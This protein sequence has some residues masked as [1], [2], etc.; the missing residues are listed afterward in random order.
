MRER[1]EDDKPLQEV[2]ESLIKN[3]PNLTVLLQLG[4]R[5][6]A[7][8]NT[9]PTG[10][11]KKEFK[12]EVYPR[13]FKIK[14]VEYGEVFERDCPINF[15]MRFTF[16]TDARDDYFTRRIEK[17][18][19]K[20]TILEASGTERQTSP[21]GPNLRNGIAT[22]GI[23]LPEGAR[24]GD[25]ITYLARVQDSRK[26]FENRIV[27]TVKQEAAKSSGGGGRRNPP[28]DR[29][30]DDR[31]R[32]RRLG[33]PQIEQIYRED[34][35]KHDFD[36]FTAMKIEAVGYAGEE[37]NTEL[38]AFKVNMD[39]TPMMNEIKEKRLDDQLARKQFMYA[40]V[41]VGL[42]LLLQEKQRP[43]TS[44]EN[45]NSEM[46]RSISIE[47]Q[48]ESTCRAL[49]PFMLALTSLGDADLGLDEAVE[50]LEESA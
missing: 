19:F 25:K 44:V 10:S 27:V 7:P 39:N 20:L 43:K 8:F 3:S 33:Q 6:S 11:E 18:A 47:Q 15:G 30:G 1:L 41:L 42:S 13:F 12:G 48:V 29:A 40:N 36:E 14:G 38:Y 49:A 4:Q 34:W 2:L 17:G 45:G 26:S 24:I 5:I 37:D 35:D 21:T 46:P 31:E 9:K 22:V 23:E 28:R 32:P 50:G 16:E